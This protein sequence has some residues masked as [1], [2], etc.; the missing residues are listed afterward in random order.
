MVGDDGDDWLYGDTGADLFRGGAGTDTV[1]YR[2][3]GQNLTLDLTD[4][5]GNDGAAGEGDN[6]EFTVENAIGGN[7]NDTIYGSSAD[8]VLNGDNGNDTIYG[9]VGNDTINGGACLPGGANSNVG[10]EGNDYFW[11]DNTGADLFRG[12]S[13]TDTVDYSHR[14][15]NM[16]ISLDN[17]GNDGASGEADNVEDTVENV[18]TGNGND[19]ITGSASPNA[20]NTNG[21]SDTIRGQSGNDTIN[22]GAGSDWVYGDN[23]NDRIYALDGFIDYVYGGNGTDTLADS[24]GND[25]VY[26]IEVRL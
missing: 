24:D 2:G 4:N 25:Q 18:T 23:D 9:R 11:A 14:N 3:R 13:G 17:G 15:E 7:G 1:D 6:I 10:D 16:N 22:G 8:N 21:G 12:G 19:S 20:I 26:E 5:D